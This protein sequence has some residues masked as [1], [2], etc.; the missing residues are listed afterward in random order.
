MPSFLPPARAPPPQKKNLLQIVRTLSVEWGRE[1]LR[2]IIF[3]Y[4]Q[5]LHFSQAFETPKGRVEGI[6]KMIEEKGTGKDRKSNF[7]CTV[8]L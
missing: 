4:P 1:S 6:T 3:L 8:A 5:S 2:A 7:F